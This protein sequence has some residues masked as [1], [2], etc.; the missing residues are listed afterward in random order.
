M[1]RHKIKIFVPSDLESL[2]LLKD[3]S[4]QLIISRY[5]DINEIKDELSNEYNI[6]I[7]KEDKSLLNISGSAI[8]INQRNLNN[9]TLSMAAEI[10]LLRRRQYILSMISDYSAKIHKSRTVEEVWKTLKLGLAGELGCKTLALTYR[11][12]NREWKGWLFN[13]G[14][15]IPIYEDYTTSGTDVISIYG[16]KGDTEAHLVIAEWSKNYTKGECEMI[17]KELMY[18]LTLSLNEALISEKLKEISTKDKLTGLLKTQL[19]ESI[20]ETEISRADRTGNLISVAILEVE[21]LRRV[22]SMYGHE[23]GDRILESVATTIKTYLRNEDYAFRYG[24]TSFVIISHIQ[25]P[26]QTEVIKARLQE[27]LTTTILEE[28]EE[29]ATI[30]F[31]MGFA[32]YPFDDITPRGLLN[33]ASQKAHGG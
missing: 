1:H 33:I 32:I 28:I 6:I 26:Q 31:R 3:K 8:F 9:E 4:K 24:D 12:N 17:L 2:P 22:N 10:A 5:D 18:P 13:H 15:E 29:T 11:Y 30:Y 16:S 7:T 27:A 23:V 21:G 25:K 14:L 20:L 19:I